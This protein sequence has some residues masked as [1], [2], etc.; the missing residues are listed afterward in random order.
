[1]RARSRRD[2]LRDVPGSKGEEA[3]G[4]FDVEGLRRHFGEILSKYRDES[5]D[6]PNAVCEF[7]W[8]VYFG[9]LN[10][11]YGMDRRLKISKFIILLMAHL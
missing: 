3:F 5:I 11:F 10:Y 9:N 2:A 4:K 8:K 7:L 6:N 1:M